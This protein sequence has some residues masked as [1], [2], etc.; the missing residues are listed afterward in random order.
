MTLQ[1]ELR[2]QTEAWI[3]DQARQYGVEPAEVVQRLVEAQL[4]K[5]AAPHIE[6]PTIE[7]LRSWIDE[8]STEDPDEIRDAEKKL[9]EFKRAM[10]TPR[11]EAGARLLFPEVE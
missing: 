6:D 3:Q 7:L 10:N 1:I 8:D 5:E 4:S 11:R 2:P 9:L